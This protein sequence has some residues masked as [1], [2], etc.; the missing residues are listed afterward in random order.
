MKFQIIGTQEVLISHSGLVLAGTLLQATE[1]KRR[2]DRIKLDSG[3]T[4]KISHGD[5][6]LS[7]IGLFSQRGTSRGLATLPV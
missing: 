4:P 3:G 2:L 5:N 7:M 1:L 6:V